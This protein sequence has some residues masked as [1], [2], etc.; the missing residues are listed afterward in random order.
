[1]IEFDLVAWDDPEDKDG[2][3]QHVANHDV[4]VEEFEEI[5]ESST[6]SDDF[7]ESS[8]RP[9]RFGWTSTG[10]HIAVVY[11]IEREGGFTIIYPV[12]AYEVPPLT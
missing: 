3:V 10:K 11:E 8:G 12:T 6:A 4:T 7:S 9:I 5:L 2:N 1:M